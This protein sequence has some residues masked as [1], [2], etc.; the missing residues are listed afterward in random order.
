VA[1]AAG[2]IPGLT[3]MIKNHKILKMHS[4]RIPRSLLRG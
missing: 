3:L 1:A 4:E 2:I